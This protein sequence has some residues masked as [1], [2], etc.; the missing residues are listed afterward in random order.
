[1]H[2]SEVVGEAVVDILADAGPVGGVSDA[3]AQRPELLGGVWWSALLSAVGAECVWVVDG[4]LDPEDVA[5]VV[6]LDA[7]RL[8]PMADSVAFVEVDDSGLEGTPGVAAY[9]SENEK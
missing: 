9:G 8:E 7:V 1:L 3:F 5:F 2:G 6:Q 4:G